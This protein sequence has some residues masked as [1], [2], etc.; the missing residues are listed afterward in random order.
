MKV[1]TTAKSICAAPYRDRCGRRSV[2]LR[3]ESD[4]ITYETES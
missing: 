3:R 2:V 4:R 1:S